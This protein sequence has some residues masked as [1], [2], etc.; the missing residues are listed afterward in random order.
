MGKKVIINGATGMVG[1]GVLLECIDDKRIEKILVLTRRPLEIES[2]KVEQIV[3]KDFFNFSDHFDRF[4]EYDAC[5]YCLGVS[6]VGMKEKEYN[7]VTYKMTLHLAK[8]LSE[9]NP[10][11]VFNYVSGKGTDVSE[12]T[13]S[14]WA[15]VKGKT[16]N[17]IEA[18]PFKSSNMF[19]PGM[20]I[21]LKG[22]RSRTGWYNTVYSF[23]RPLSPLINKLSKTPMLTT[24]MMGK[25]M[26]ASISGKKGHHKLESK[27]IVELAKS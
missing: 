8:L 6:S 5:F 20:I 22:I 2:E 18:L 4:K 25:A 3:Q 13:K 27:D 15:R 19:R 16:E 17:K 21:P 1:R 9:C 23:V 26:I 24:E 12:K 10:D 11:C 7:E 14:K